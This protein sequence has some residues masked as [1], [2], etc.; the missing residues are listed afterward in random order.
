MD[1]LIAL[2]GEPA[3]LWARTCPDGQA[4][5]ARLTV[6][7]EGIRAHMDNAD[8]AIPLFLHR[9]RHEALA[10][11]DAAALAFADELFALA[12]P[13]MCERVHASAREE[14]LPVLPIELSTAGARLRLFTMITTFGTP[15]DVTTDDLRIELF[16]P[17]DDD[18]RQLLSA[19]SASSMSSSN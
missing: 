10:A 15:Q 7:P 9:L 12:G 6:H 13:R 2:A 4:N 16:Y 17:A 5:L 1:S 3:A 14:L 19:L 8:A 18:T 11:G